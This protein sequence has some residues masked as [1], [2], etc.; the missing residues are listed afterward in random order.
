MLTTL[1]DARNLPSQINIDELLNGMQTLALKIS[2]VMKDKNEAISENLLNNVDLTVILNPKI[3]TQELNIISQKGIVP[4]IHNNLASL[5]FKAFKPVEE[6]GNSFLFDNWNN[7]EVFAA[8]VR[9]LEN[10]QFPYD[11]GNIVHAVKNVHI[12]I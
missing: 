2:F 7:W 3:S 12:E 4:L 6:D 10:Y 1:I 9:C 5:G 11:W 8:L